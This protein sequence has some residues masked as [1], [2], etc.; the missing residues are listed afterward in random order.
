[1]I[2][3]RTISMSGDLILNYKLFYLNINKLEVG[4]NER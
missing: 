3:R 4:Q 1:M 2:N